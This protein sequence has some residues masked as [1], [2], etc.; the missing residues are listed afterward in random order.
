MILLEIPGVSNHN[1]S[2][3]PNLHGFWWIFHCVCDFLTTCYPLIMDVSMSRTHITRWTKII[4]PG[5]GI[6]HWIRYYR[7]NPGKNDENRWKLLKSYHFDDCRRHDR[8]TPLGKPCWHTTRTTIER[9][10]DRTFCTCLR[11]LV[12]FLVLDTSLWHFFTFDLIPKYSTW[13]FLTEWLRYVPFPYFGNMV[14]S[15]TWHTVQFF[16]V[17]EYLDLNQF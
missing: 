13:A 11:C 12:P 5:T 4:Q 2:F 1:W 17:N 10:F 14:A 8:G 3:Q 16:I 7:E 15:S 6:N 9:K